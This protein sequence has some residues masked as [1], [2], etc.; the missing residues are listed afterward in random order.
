MAR[1]R[2]YDEDEPRADD[3][4]WTD[5]GDES[6]GSSSGD[7]GSGVSS[8]G[9]TVDHERAASSLRDSA[10]VTEHMGRLSAAGDEARARF[11]REERAGDVAHAAAQ[12]AIHTE[13]ARIHAEHDAIAGSDQARLREAADSG[14]WAAQQHNGGL[15]EQHAAALASV[16]REKE[17]VAEETADAAN[18]KESVEAGHV[19]DVVPHE[20]QDYFEAEHDRIVGELN[21]TRGALD[22]AHLAAADAIGRLDA[23]Q[24]ESDDG[25]IDL[26]EKIDA[27]GGLHEQFDST[28]NE[29][30][31]A[32]GATETEGFDRSEHHE[33][34]EFPASPEH[35]EPSE[36][37]RPN[38]SDAPEKPA[39]FEHDPDSTSEE[40]S[41]A[42]EEHQQELSEWH[43][44][45]KEFR[46]SVN[47]Y[48]ERKA[49]YIAYEHAVAAHE[50]EFKSRAA[51]AQTALET[52][53]EHQISAAE[54]LVRLEKEHGAANAARHAEVDDLE[55]DALVNQ[56]AVSHDD[57]ARERADRASESIIASEASRRLD[58]TRQPPDY[59]ALRGTLKDEMRSTAAAIK[60]LAKLTGRPARIP[61]K[62]AKP[63]KTKKSANRPSTD[64]Q[65]SVGGMAALH[66]LKLESLKFISLVDQPAQATA[67]VL[68]VKRAGAADGVKTTATL[69]IMK[70]AEGDNPL[71]YCW[72]FTCTDEN[73]QP[74]HDLQGDAISPDFIKAAEEFLASGAAS[75]E[76]HDENATGRIAFGFP[77]DGD[78]AKAFFGDAIGK[79]I[80]ASGLMVAVRASKDAVAKVRSGEYTGVSIAGTGT[81]EPIGKAAPT[82]QGCKA[83]MGKDDT[84]CKGCGMAAY[85]K[86]VLATSDRDALPDI[87]FLYVEPGGKV[88]G[89][90]TE[91][92]SLRMFPYRNSAGDINLVHLRAACADIPKSSLADALK[93]KL[94]MRAEKL[95]AKQH[96]K[97]VSKQASLTSETDGHVHTIDLDDPSDGWRDTLSTSYQTSA[98][99][100]GQHCHAWTC[101]P[102]TGAITI[103]MDSGHDHT[104]DAVVPAEVLAQ[105]AELDADPKCS[106]CG[107]ECDDGNRFCPSC[108]APMDGSAISDDKPASPTVLA[109]SMRAPAGKSPLT[110]PAPTVKG[111]SQEK[112]LMDLKFAKM[113]AT[114]LL[115]PEAQRTHV[116]KLAAEEPAALQAFLSLDAASREDA[117]NAALAA[118]PVVYT[119]KT[120]GQIRKSH[121][122]MAKSQAEQIDRQAEQIATQESVLAVAKARTEQA[123]LEKRAVEIIPL[124]GKSAGARVAILKGVS[125]ITD[126]AL[127]T[128]AME[129]LKGANAAFAQLGKASGTD[130]GGEPTGNDP[131]SIFNAEL[132]AFAKSVSKTA[133]MAT[134]DFIRTERGSEL[135][136]D[137]YPRTQAS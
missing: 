11:P 85:G 137:A 129:A 86:G 69:R 42:Q 93:T 64:A 134:G 66:R 91:P 71:I 97:R 44:A 20:A 75:D 110:T 3:G 87:A 83:A 68:L 13:A 98:G 61:S 53:H 123:E 100:T 103:A 128:E 16:G 84:A 109:I 119:T 47:N 79:Q 58:D 77:M 2:K 122:E 101:D 94:Q 95:L 62:P 40:N 30:A 39:P 117:T 99:A 81:R 111:N 121:G 72:A 78:I 70:V 126:E 116:A 80:K 56:G 132:A 34:V 63:G 24:A 1:L 124:I 104:V 27:V 6:G 118:D 46:E 17:R 38:P 29:L 131:K 96:S 55:G 43:E 12:T 22:E 41:A 60:Q 19:N 48:D 92:K 133:A 28:S 59:D 88:V 9:S 4:R 52:L 45:D 125:A 50:A 107:A 74:Y 106:K 21:D 15:A 89:G 37:D 49:E 26:A 54:K 102:T 127:R 120:G 130:G 35:G 25:E 23:V 113:L 57:A 8:G 108:G 136:A 5:G 14:R 105:A 33:M 67:K 36:D 18:V 31:G 73:G 10:F 135:Y 51:D 115:L 82:C 32:T 112:P 65:A 76:M 114:A 90:K 7:A